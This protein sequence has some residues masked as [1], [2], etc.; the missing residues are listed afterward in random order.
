MAHQSVGSGGFSSGAVGRRGCIGASA[1][2]DFKARQKLMR[3]VVHGHRLCRET[4]GSSYETRNGW[5]LL[6]EA[7]ETAPLEI[8]ILDSRNRENFWA[9]LFCHEAELPEAKMLLAI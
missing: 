3:H 6:G 4:A 5:A 7:L 1:R 2:K 8:L 9:E